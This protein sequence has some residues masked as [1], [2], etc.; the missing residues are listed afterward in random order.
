MRT[1][2]LIP[3]IIVVFFILLPLVIVQSDQHP[4]WQ[5]VCENGRIVVEGTDVGCYNH[6]RHPTW[7][8]Q[9]HGTV[10]VDYPDVAC[11][12]DAPPPQPTATA[13]AVTTP[14]ATATAVATNTPQ[15]SPTP[16]GG[17]VEPYPEAPQCA[18]HETHTWHGLWNYELGCYYDHEHGDDPSLADDLFGPL[19]EAWGGNGL[20]HPFSTEGEHDE[21]KHRTHKVT[22]RTGLDCISINADGCVTDLR[23]LHHLDFF[24]S[25]TR[26]HSY[27]L[28]ARVCTVDESTDCGIIKRGGWLDFGPLINQIPDEQIAVPDDNL[29]PFRGTARRLHRDDNTFSVWYGQQYRQSHDG[30][31]T[32]L[33]TIQIGSEVSHGWTYLD[34]DD[35]FNLIFECENGQCRFNSSNRQQGH[36]MNFR[37][38]STLFGSRANATGFTDVYGIVDPGCTEVGPTCVPFV[39]EN[40]RTDIDYQHRDGVQ[41]YGKINY[42]ISPPDTWWI[43]FPN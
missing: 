41:D 43:T 42:D 38:N 26:F 19:G 11:Y 24:N 22:V 6:P 34:P 12:E 30:D 21:F 33:G 35:P 37:L 13:T 5:D 17:P 32:G 31:N 18:D 25:T 9:C 39:L 7:L 20:D 14:T 40:V 10:V 28:E 15:P 8:N 3:S 36:L 27:W 23:I 4:T 1:S 2:K 16:G 29:F